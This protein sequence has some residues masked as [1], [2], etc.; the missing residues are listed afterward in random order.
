MFNK[1]LIVSTLSAI[2]ISGQA[3]S[4]DRIDWSGEFR[5]RFERISTG[6]TGANAATI[7]GKSPVRNRQRIKAKIGAAAKVNDNLSAKMVL[8][9]ST[10]DSDPVS[11]NSTLAGGASDKTIAIDVAQFV[12]KPEYVTV[13]GG[14][15]KVPFY[16]PGK[17]QMLF[18]G[19]LRPEGLSIAHGN[20]MKGWGYN[21]TAAHWELEE[22]GTRTESTMNGIQAIFD[23]D[24]GMLDIKVG[25]A[26]LVYANLQNR[27]TLFDATDSFGNSTTGTNYATNFNITEYFLQLSS[28]IGGYPISIYA[29]MS[30]NGSAT[31]DDAASAYGLIFGKAKKKGSWSFGYLRKEVEKDSVVGAFTDSDFGDGGTDHKGGVYSFKYAVADNVFVKATHFINDTAVKTAANSRDYKR[32][33]LDFS[34]KF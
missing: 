33:Q 2:V 22:S 11:S 4:A 19:D 16:V 17:N 30:K 34:F 28:K 18:D 24:A 32:T 10:A 13:T 6:A 20:K 3:I 1:L 31:I 15:S 14:K 26:K 8:A 12:W 7:S 9:S 23:I 5:Y 27:S 21:V 25:A 29:D